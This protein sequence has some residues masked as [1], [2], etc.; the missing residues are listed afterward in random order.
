M[1]PYLFRPKLMHCRS[2]VYQ[3]LAEFK[4]NVEPSS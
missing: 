1:D 3:E 4:R 2:W